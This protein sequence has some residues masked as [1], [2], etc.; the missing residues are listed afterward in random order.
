MMNE[1]W[2]STCQNEKSVSRLQGFLRSKTATPALLLVIAVLLFANFVTSF[3]E[4][5]YTDEAA[6]ADQAYAWVQEQDPLGT[7]VA[8][9]E[10]LGLLEFLN[11]DA[12]AA[13]VVSTEMAPLSYTVHDFQTGEDNQIALS[14]GTLADIEKYGQSLPDPMYVA[15]DNADILPYHTYIEHQLPPTWH[16]NKS[17][18]TWLW[19]KPTD[20]IDNDGNP[21]IEWQVGSNEEGQLFEFRQAER[22]NDRQHYYELVW[23]Q[24]GNTMIQLVPRS[25]VVKVSTCD[26]EADPSNMAAYIKVEP[27]GMLNFVY[28]QGE[29]LFSVHA[30]SCAGIKYLAWDLPMRIPY[31]V[32]DTESLLTY[33]WHL[34]MGCHEWDYSNGFCWSYETNI[35]Q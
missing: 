10:R 6:W 12:Q 30:V 27:D 5:K 25:N 7:V 9:A 17:A 19:V 16:V 1:S 3:F 26:V 23:H 2:D 34:P 31:G 22:P 15:K 33:Q 35:A 14:A 29:P 13:E 28:P 24:N 4:V 8:I 32:V 11:D 21:Y 20:H 18:Y